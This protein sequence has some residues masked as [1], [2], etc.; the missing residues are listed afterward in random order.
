MLLYLTGGATS[1]AKTSEVPQDDPM[2][3]LGGYV[4]SSPVPNASLNAVFDCIS[5]HT[6]KNRPKETVAIALVN[7][8]EEAVKNVYIRTIVSPDNIAKIRI[9]AVAIG[10]EMEMEHIPNRYAEPIN[11]EF[12]DTS[13][14]RAFVDFEIINPVSV[15]EDI[16]FEQF[17]VLAEIEEPEIEGNADALIKAFS[18]SQ[19]YE[20]KRLSERRF[21]VTSKDDTM[22]IEPFTPTYISSDENAKYEF[23]GQFKLS[24]NTA[25]LT[26]ELKPGEAIGLWIQRDITEVPTRTNYEIIK[27]DDEHR[28]FDTVE[29]IEI[30]IDYDN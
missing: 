28:I 26:E 30:V 1:L 5:L 12:V 19:D 11:A 10:D 14:I 18:K 17:G 21:R 6:L 16:F 23:V 15:G 9:A 3:S 7:K 25:F 27:D 20:L 4:S 22:E 2:K 29:E 13:Y 8:F 24:S